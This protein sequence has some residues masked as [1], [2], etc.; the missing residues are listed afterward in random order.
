MQQRKKPLIK[1][2]GEGVG[3]VEMMNTRTNGNKQGPKKK[4]ILNKE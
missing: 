4:D 2:V 1:A 3:G